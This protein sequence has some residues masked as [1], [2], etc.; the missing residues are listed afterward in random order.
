LQI[1]TGLE[2]IGLA[3]TAWTAYRYFLVDGEKSKMT[4]EIKGFATKVG[5]DLDI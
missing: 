4:S 5:V 1:S 3:F 2:L